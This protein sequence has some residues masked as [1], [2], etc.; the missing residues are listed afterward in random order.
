MNATLEKVEVVKS[1]K[2]NT[3][4]VYKKGQSRLYLTKFRSFN[5]CSKM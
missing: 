2:Y 3:E 5:V 1:C 4:A